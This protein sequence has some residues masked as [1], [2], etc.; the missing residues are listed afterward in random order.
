M[1][2]PR[3]VG[4]LK[5]NRPVRKLK[6]SR[7]NLLGTGGKAEAA[8]SQ[9][10]ADRCNHD[11]QAFQFQ[12]VNTGTGTQYRRVGPQVTVVVVLIMC[13]MEF[14]ARSLLLPGL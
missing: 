6:A 3:R 8:S 7:R 11:L 12:N 10:E 9:T 5:V 1:T 13:P 2:H 14:R 4:A